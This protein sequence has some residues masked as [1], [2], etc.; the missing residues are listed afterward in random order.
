M[1][2]QS[3]TVDLKYKTGVTDKVICRLRQSDG[4]PVDLS[5]FDSVV[6][7]MSDNGGHSF[8]V[9]CTIGNARYSASEGGVTINFTDTELAYESEYESEFVA[10]LNGDITRIPSDDNWYTLVIYHAVEV[11]T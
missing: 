6:F 1:S 2:T 5:V 4:S 8:S 9:P 11:T 3:G 7:N 10:Y